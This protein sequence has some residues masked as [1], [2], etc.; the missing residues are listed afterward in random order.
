MIVKGYL[1]IL[2]LDLTKV[3]PK[4]HKIL[5][6]QHLK[7]IENYKIEQQNLP[8]HLKYENAIGEAYR[9]MEYHNKIRAKRYIKSYA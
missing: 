6:E 3:D 2:D 1:G 5:I 8:D 7:D 9:K 4:F